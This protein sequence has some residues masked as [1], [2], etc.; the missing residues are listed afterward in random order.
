MPLSNLASYPPTMNEFISHWEQVNAAI[1]PDLTIVAPDKTSVT[2]ATFTALRETL[3]VQVQ[4]VIGFLNDKEIA[5]GD[6]RLRKTR[7]LALFNEFNAVLDGYYVGT[8]FINARPYA[9]SSSDAVEVFLMPMRDALSLWQKLAAGPAPAGITLPLVLADGTGSD[10]FE[11]LIQGLQSAQAAEANANQNAVL[12][13]GKRDITMALAKA[14]MVTYRKAV[15]A[16]CVLHP[17]LVAA[18]P[19]VTPPPGHT[20]DPVNASA[21]FQAPDQAKIV[22]DAS[23][24][25]TLARYELRGNPGDTYDENDAVTI[26]SHLPADPREFLTGFGLTQP[27]THAAFKV[28]VVLDTG[29]EAGSATMIVARPG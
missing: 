16:R 2:R 19:A 6:I 3:L 4:N 13:R 20:P 22:Y 9:P 1:D 21:V 10:D 14:L 17:E 23:E 26:T 27:G 8:P 5:R 18:M 24:E 29:N 12:A 25:T 11:E 15:P 28:F 7:L